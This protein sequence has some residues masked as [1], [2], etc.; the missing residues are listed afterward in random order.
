MKQILF[1]IMALYSCISY[2][3]PKSNFKLTNIT[4]I[5]S[6]FSYGY[7]LSDSIQAH[8]IQKKPLIQDD[9]IFILHNIIDKYY[10]GYLI[11]QLDVQTGKTNWQRYFNSE[12]LNDRE[13]AYDFK[14]INNSINLSLFKENQRGAANIINP[15]WF[16]ANYNSISFDTYSGNTLRHIKTNPLDTMNRILAMPIVLAY[17]NTYS[18]HLFQR[19]NST[20]YVQQKV[21]LIDDKADEMVLDL[22]SLDTLGHVL[23]SSQFSFPINQIIKKVQIIEYDDQKYFSFIFGHDELNPKV[24]RNITMLYFDEN[25]EFLN[26]VVLTDLIDP[27]EFYAIIDYN[28]DYFIVMGNENIPSS[29]DIISTFYLFDHNGNLKEKIRLDNTPYNKYSDNAMATY[30]ENNKK[31]LIVVAKKRVNMNNIIF[32]NSDGNGQIE[33]T[34]IC[35]VKNQKNNLA[36]NQLSTV[37]LDKLLINFMYV[38]ELSTITPIPKWS[39][40]TLL[41]LKD[42]GIKTSTENLIKDVE[43][44]MFPNPIVNELNIDAKIIFDQL[45]IYDVQGHL[46]KSVFNKYNTIDMSDLKN[47]IYFCDI[48]REGKSIGKHKFIKLN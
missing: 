13:F 7:G 35:E 28:K 12:K 26:K 20:L 16:R 34:K 24:G 2:S 5:W 15:L 4:P 17:V 18:T 22:I 29:D 19:S 1:V 43:V 14:L 27:A 46:V 10:Q 44:K 45:D 9:N 47:G 6:H 33:N 41:D 32:I 31:M 30:L 38:D 25:F 8:I 40:W 21:A 36:V 42:L 48:I 39:N 3:Q 37:G 11:E 23:D